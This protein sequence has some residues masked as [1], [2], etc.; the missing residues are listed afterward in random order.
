MPSE[1]TAWLSQQ[2]RDVMHAAW[3]GGTCTCAAPSSVSL[4]LAA[5]GFDQADRFPW[6][7]CYGN[8]YIC[9][10]KKNPGVPSMTSLIYRTE[11]VSVLFFVHA[12]HSIHGQTLDCDWG[13]SRK[14]APVDSDWWSQRIKDTR[15]QTETLVR[16]WLTSHLCLVN[17]AVVSL[18]A[19]CLIEK[20]RPVVWIGS[21]S[22]V[23]LRF[24][25][26]KATL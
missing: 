21:G 26:S 5:S 12:R 23:A 19:Q 16:H 25:S 11:S 15:S 22:Q 13:M 3:K 9:L 4:L 17:Y 6:K 24:S 18:S 1:H 7:L 2:L 10:P 20:Y 8:K 14:L